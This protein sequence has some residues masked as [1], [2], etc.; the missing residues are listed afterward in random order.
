MQAVAGGQHVKLDAN[1]LLPEPAERWEEL[2]ESITAVSGRPTWI[3]HQLEVLALQGHLPSRVP[4]RRA[5]AKGAQG[6]PGDPPPKRC[7]T[8]WGHLGV[9]CSWSVCVVCSVCTKQEGVSAG[10]TML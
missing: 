6:L 5:A 9:L 1:P 8:W 7:H 4:Q 10:P 3:L 2:G